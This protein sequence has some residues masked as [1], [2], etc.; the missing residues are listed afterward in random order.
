MKEKS[1]LIE[2]CKICDNRCDYCQFDCNCSTLVDPT[3]RRPSRVERGL[4]N[5]MLKKVPVLKDEAKQS[6][7]KALEEL[8]TVDWTET[9]GSDVEKILKDNLLGGISVH[10]GYWL[11]LVEKET[12]LNQFQKYVLKNTIL[13][14]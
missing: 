8:N 2:A 4:K 9:D 10:K 7:K 3:E 14:N 11:D 12:S 1:R 5:G 6:F 13:M